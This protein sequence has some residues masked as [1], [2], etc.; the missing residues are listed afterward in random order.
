MSDFNL[1]IYSTVFVH[2]HAFTRGVFLHLTW[3]Q[4]THLHVGCTGLSPCA[5][6]QLRVSAVFTI[7]RLHQ[8][9]QSVNDF[10]RKAHPTRTLG[11]ELPNSTRPCQHTACEC[12]CVCLSCITSCCHL[13]NEYQGCVRNNHSWWSFII[14]SSAWTT[15]SRQF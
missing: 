11:N 6:C 2:L 3:K 13:L 12:V 5:P 1:C 15:L 4:N 9:F 14:D 10:Q 8:A 7:S